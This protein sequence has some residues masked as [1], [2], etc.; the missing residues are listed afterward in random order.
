LDIFDKK[1]EKEENSRG[2]KKEDFTQILSG[3]FED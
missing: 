2:L 1:K 3:L